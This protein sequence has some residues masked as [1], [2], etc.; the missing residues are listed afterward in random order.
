MLLSM[1]G[2]ALSVVLAWWAVQVLRTSMPEGVPRVTTIAL[3]LR[4]L[5]AA[6]GLALVT[7]IL[8]GIVPALQLSRPDLT[9]ALKD[10]SRGSVGAGRQRLRSALV[11][12]E[13][14]LAVVL[15]VGAALFIGSFVT[16]MRIDPG[17]DAKNVL[18][19]QVFPR[20]EPGKPPADH[21][22]SYSDIVSR[23]AQAPGVQYASFI[24]GGMPL[25]GS[26]SST[27]LEIP[28]RPKGEDREGISI[29][30]VTADYHRAMGIPLKRGRLF[31][32]ED[33]ANAPKVMIINESAAA[34]YF[35]GEDPLGKVGK[36]N[37][38]DR[39][40]VGVVGDVLQVS[41]EAAARS[42]AYVPMPQDSRSPRA[43][44]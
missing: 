43:S 9:R 32:A 6:A 7:G 11:V 5:A 26:M 33:R 22:A 12:A 35:P 18:T 19:V 30:H 23:I 2:A 31:T 24:A 38:A 39:T 4:V 29:R 34:R 42:E 14:A 10:G 21:S 41:L 3:D 13:V 16:L 17:F 20:F 44:W 27:S 25:G 8:F 28:G 36:I 15:L 1:I 40:I 37:D